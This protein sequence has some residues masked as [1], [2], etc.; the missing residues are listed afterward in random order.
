MKKYLAK[1]KLKSAYKEEINKQIKAIKKDGTYDKLKAKY[2]D[3][4]N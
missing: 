2:I 3:S 1:S 4:A